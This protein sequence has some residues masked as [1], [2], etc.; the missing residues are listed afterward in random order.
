MFVGVALVLVSLF[1]LV[2]S[3][4]VLDTSSCKRNWCVIFSI[5]TGALLIIEQNERAA[6]SATI[7]I[8]GIIINYAFPV[9]LNVIQAFNRKSDP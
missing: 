7:I 4:D 8:T 3:N 9:L 1:I 6:L 5:V 2:M